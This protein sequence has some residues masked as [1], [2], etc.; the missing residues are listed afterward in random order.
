MSD[1]NNTSVIERR[2]D[3]K[4]YR[5]VFDLPL[6]DPSAE[7]VRDLSSNGVKDIGEEDQST[8]VKSSDVVSPDSRIGEEAAKAEESID[9]SDTEKLKQTFEQTLAEYNQ[10][11]QKAVENEEEIKRLG[12]ELGMASENIT[13]AIVDE[14]YGFVHPR[15]PTPVINRRFL[16]Q[17]S[18]IANQSQK[19]R[20]IEEKL[21]QLGDK[22]EVFEALNEKLKDNFKDLLGNCKTSKDVS[23]LRDYINNLEFM[24]S[25]LEIFDKTKVEA[26]YKDLKQG[27]GA[28]C[29]AWIV[30][31]N[32]K[33]ITEVKEPG[34]EL[35]KIDDKSPALEPKDNREPVFTSAPA[36][37]T[38]LIS[39]ISKQEPLNNG[40]TPIDLT[41]S[42]IPLDQSS[43]SNK[44]LNKTLPDQSNEPAIIPVN[45]TQ[46]NS[47]IKVDESV[48]SGNMEEFVV[49]KGN[50]SATGEAKTVTPED[51]IST[52]KGL[53]EL[54]VGPV[55]KPAS[56]PE[57][58]IAQIKQGFLQDNIPESK[59]PVENESA[60]ETLTDF[61]GKEVKV[62]YES[63]DDAGAM[64][65]VESE[66]P[67]STKPPVNTDGN[68]ALNDLLPPAPENRPKSMAAETD[69]NSVKEKPK[70]RGFGEFIAGLFKGNEDVDANVISQ[71]EKQIIALREQENKS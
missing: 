15:T 59:K 65:V 18:E 36:E 35:P 34:R 64:P 56:D 21:K 27:F 71:K 31:L 17:R 63:T 51:E 3:D 10:K 24:D 57:H 13:A 33:K 66:T 45:I 68:S 55:P 7:T 39:N 47:E 60:T 11:I 61:N 48:S 44:I 70:R 16:Q 30:R 9:V 37:K 19:I 46:K 32:R 14:E 8:L 50:G 12:K 42:E 58:K 43:V 29:L 40:V 49:F 38:A 28:D 25:D 54:G 52:V 67:T 53:G 4:Q 5:D 6:N 22:G 26:R 41:G 69:N 20:E 1:Q 23:E 62:N 2:T